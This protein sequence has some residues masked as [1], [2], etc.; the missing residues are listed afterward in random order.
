MSFELDGANELSAI[1]AMLHKEKLSPYQKQ[2]R[3]FI[4]IEG[5]IRFLELYAQNEIGN[6]EVDIE[7]VAL[8]VNSPAFENVDVYRIK[9]IKSVYKMLSDDI[10]ERNI[11]LHR[12]LKLNEYQLRIFEKEHHQ[13]LIDDFY[14]D[15]EKYPCLKCIWY[16]NGITDFGR[17]SKCK[18]PQISRSFSFT[19][20]GYHDISSKRSRNCRH[21]TTVDNVE[22]FISQSIIGN[23]SLSG[24]EQ[25]K[26]IK[27]AKELSKKWN[28][29]VSNLDNSY[30]P[31]FIPDSAKLRLDESDDVYEELGRAFK[32]KK[33][34]SEMKK[35]L[36]FAIFL[37]AMIK[38]IEVYAQTEMGNDY[39]ADIA[40][41]ASFVDSRSHQDLFK[42]TSEEELYK[43]LEEYAVENEAFVRRLI[44]RKET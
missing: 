6:V 12:F 31:L 40:K 13:T 4:Y 7:K 10:I 37:S 3:K 38:F 21:N 34:K 39:I 15:C 9:S 36:R 25:E 43:M 14:K 5:L 30:I 2:H 19:R 20:A 41:I 24:F 26:I 28:E 44:K 11:P 18:L 42:F 33:P 23:A 1:G 22:K 29:K 32:N 35:N 17:F 8:W 16:E 27:A